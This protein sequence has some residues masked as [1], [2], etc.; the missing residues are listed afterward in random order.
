[1][2]IQSESQPTKPPPDQVRSDCPDCDARLAILRVIAGKAGS[3][4]WTMR[5]TRCGGVHLDIV[6]PSR[7]PASVMQLT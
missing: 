2:S 7:A 3:E 1:M 4:Y 5:C 6:K